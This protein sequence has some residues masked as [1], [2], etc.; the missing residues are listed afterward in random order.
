VLIGRF[1]PA[2]PTLRPILE[3]FYQNAFAAG[4]YGYASVAIVLLLFI[5][6]LVTFLQFKLQKRWVHYE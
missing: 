2:Y 3:F 4:K 6:G 1:N 5:I